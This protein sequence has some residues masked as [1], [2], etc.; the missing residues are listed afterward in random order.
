MAT[1]IKPFNNYIIE[2][3]PNQY[4]VI[5]NQVEYITKSY[6]SVGLFFNAE[7]AGRITFYDEVSVKPSFLYP[8]GGPVLNFHVNQF[9]DIMNIIRY[10][11]PLYIYL[12]TDNWYGYIGTTAEP[13]GEEES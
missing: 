12:N 1:I 10:E 2:Y 6:A 8:G 4:A 5:G 7:I 9:T 13:V 3:H 11:K